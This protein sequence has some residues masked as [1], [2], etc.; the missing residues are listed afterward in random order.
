[1]KG[2]MIYQNNSWFVKHPECKIPYGQKF[3]KKINL[4]PIHP[5]NM[6][7]IRCYSRVFD[8]IEARIL[9]NPIV[10]FELIKIENK[11]Y[12]KVKNI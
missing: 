6:N 8:N 5:E 7:S 11:E 12:A 1:M 2:E 10:D 3:C 9:S 4:T